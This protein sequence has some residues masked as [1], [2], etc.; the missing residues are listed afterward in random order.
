MRPRLRPLVLVLALLVAA[1]GS[2]D[3]GDLT[4]ARPTVAETDTPG[5]DHAPPAAAGADRVAGS[6]LQQTLVPQP[7]VT[8]YQGAVLDRP[9]PKPDFTLT[10]TSGEPYDFRAETADAAVTFLY[11]GYTTCPDICPGHMAALATALREVDPAVAEEVEVVFVSVDPERDEDLLRQYLDSF[12]E[13]F[14]GLTGEPA[15]INR[16]MDGMGLHPSAI[17]EDGDFPPSHP[18]NIITFTGESSQI[19]YPFGVNGA[20]IAQD[21]PRLVDEGVV[22]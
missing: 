10:D 14:V 5:H 15:E 18:I 8:G 2:G 4:A 21:L 17:A 13:S 6:Q 9:V 1:C 11:F 20:A 7:D 22:L 12:D 3:A 16:V 19:A